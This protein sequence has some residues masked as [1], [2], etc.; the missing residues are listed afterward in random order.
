METDVK[1]TTVTPI[2]GP[3][4]LPKEKIA[5]KR[6]EKSST[7]DIHPVDQVPHFGVLGTMALQHVLIMYTGAVAVP[8]VFGSAL[9]LDNATIAFLISADLLVCGIITI[10]QSV[11][12]TRF[13]GI[14][15]PIIAGAVFT[16]VGP[17][18]S[19]GQTYGLPAVYGSMIA[20]GVFGLLIAKPFSKLLRFFP[21]VVAGTIILVI[22]LSLINVGV[23]LVAGQ[24][25]T[26]EDYAKP[27]NLVIGAVTV[28]FII[29]VTVFA[30]GFISRIAVLLAVICGTVALIP[31]GMVD[32]Q[33]MNEASWFGMVTPLHFG[34]P[35]FPIAAVVMMC[36]VMLVTFVESTAT[37]IAVGATVGRPATEDDIARGVAADAVSGIF[38]GFFNSF[39]DSVF[40]QN[41]GLVSITK[42]RSRWVTAAAGV[43]LIVLGLI[44]KMGA[45][46]ASIPGPVIGGTAL[47]LFGSV[48]VVGVQRLA[49]VRWEGTHNEIIVAASLSIALIPVVAPTLYQD[50]PD[51]FQMF[52]GNAIIAAAIVSFTLNLICN[53]IFKKSQD[54]SALEEDPTNEY[55]DV[56]TKQ[57]S[58]PVTASTY[59]ET[60]T[61]NAEG[62]TTED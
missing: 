20:A 31:M 41:V 22:G 25:V 55:A 42:V 10:V 62:P 60:L 39:I 13:L 53:E 46:V 61:G 59:S 3:V 49:Q 23:G 50:M 8:L 44:P 51:S 17:M 5:L 36:I 27:S 32:S 18:I 48:A 35:E 57:H 29:V 7:N 6:R 47:I 28:L 4:L 15:L 33:G 54:N 37:M 1:R 16:A 34:P 40:V 19:I 12:V 45:L 11:G 9:G 30:K 21:D 43:I 38:A 14:R 58:D 52:F 56:I 24:D 2:Q 26:A